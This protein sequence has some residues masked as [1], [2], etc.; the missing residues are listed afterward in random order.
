MNKRIL[1]KSGLEV[2][3]M[4]FGC[5]GL[6]FGYGPATDKQQAINLIREA[7]DQGIT[8]LIPPKLM[9]KKMWT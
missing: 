4:G 3:A 6:S 7:F 1:G 8:F 5:M 9:A 2:S